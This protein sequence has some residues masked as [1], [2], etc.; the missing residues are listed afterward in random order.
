MRYIRAI[1]L[2]VLLFAVTLLAT[3]GSNP[4]LPEEVE[5]VYQTDVRSDY[6]EECYVGDLY[7]I[8][9]RDGSMSYKT[10]YLDPWG[11]EDIRYWY[12]KMQGVYYL[13]HRKSCLDSKGLGV[14]GTNA[15]W[16]A[17]ME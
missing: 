17:S 15:E 2:C 3:Q 9:N 7:T 13:R 10:V 11:H 1:A 14:E 6:R 4:L 8:Y 16:L 5:R 12:S